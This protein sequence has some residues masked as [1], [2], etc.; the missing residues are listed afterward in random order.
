MLMLVD[1]DCREISA[2]NLE[3]RIAFEDFKVKLITI[4]LKFLAVVT[5]EW[6]APRNY[7]KLS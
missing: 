6:L 2:K 1:V 4:I 3:A 7:L 5:N